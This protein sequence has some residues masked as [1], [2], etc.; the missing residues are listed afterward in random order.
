M[1]SKKILSV[2]ILFFAL[3]SFGQTNFK[4]SP[5]KPHAGDAINITYTPSGDITNVTAPLEGIVYT[6]GSKGQKTDD[7]KLKKTGNEYTGTVTTDTSDNFVFFSFSSDKKFDNNSNN[8]YW[9]Q[10]YDG[11]K[12]KKGANNSTALFYEYY[13]RDAGIDANN[14]KAL[15][16]M[17]AEFKSYPESKK[18]DLTSYVRLYLQ[19]NRNAG[20]TFIQNEIEEELKSGLKVENDYNVVQSLYKL[21]KLPEQ[22]KLIETLKKEKFPEGQWASDEYVQQ[23]LA[24]KDLDKKQAMLDNIISKIKIDPAWKYLEPS[25]PYF[26]SAILTAYIKIKDWNGMKSAIAKYDIK[27]AELASLY[28]NNAWEIQ[29]TDSNLNISEE[30]SKTATEWAKGEWK[31]P[32]GEKPDYYSTR[33]WEE[34]RATTYATYADTYAMILYKKGDYKQGFSYTKDAAINI[35]K[36]KDADL[37]NTYALLAEK[38]LSQKEY[39]KQIEQFVK[40]G[41]STSDMK[42]ILKRAYIKKHQS[43]NGYDDYITA[44]EKDGYLKMIADIKKGMLSDKAPAFTLVDLKGNKVNIADLKDKIVVVDFWATWCGPCKASFPAMQKMVVKYKEDPEVKFVFV[45]TWEQEANKEKNA[46]DFIVSHKYDFH[47]LMDNDSKVVN[48]FNVTGIPTKFIID[49]TGIIR[50]KSIGFDGSDDKLVSEL[51]AMIDM[52]KSM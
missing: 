3:N 17:E 24:E 30:M 40:D 52:A 42:D 20:P 50:F 33:Q 34:A 19:V 11:D 16:Y 4:F 12:I 6:L 49:K 23:Y 37:N 7:I 45:D 18:K 21:A 9:I 35:S 22:S 41:K 47:V 51:S 1:C 31:K 5:E 48:E 46:A 28:N 25:L 10:L 14:E 43:E 32:A 36:G 39:V 27:G 2:V 38:T 13:G 44:L 29:K 15:Q 26:K 8:G